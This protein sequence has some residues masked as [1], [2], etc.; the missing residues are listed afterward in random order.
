MTG[1]VL[2]ED[3]LVTIQGQRV[4]AE[5]KAILLDRLRSGE[6]MPGELE[7]PTVMRRFGAIFLDALIIGLPFAVIGGVMGASGNLDL[8]QNGILT[9]ISTAVTVIYFGAM[10]ARN[11]QTLGKMAAKLYVVKN[12]DGSKIST[13]TAY[14]RSLVY[15]GLSFLSAFAEMTGAPVIIGVAAI[16]VGIWGIANVLFALFDRDRQ[17]ALHDRITGTR[18]IHKP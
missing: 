15:G 3:E 12:S 7:K 18:V 4:S 2:P 8:V 13:G 11:G 5:G 1:Q 10:H 16:I 9:F 6:T 17:R 14:L